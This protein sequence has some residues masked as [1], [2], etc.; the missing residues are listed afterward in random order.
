MSLAQSLPAQDAAR[1]APPPSAV[2]P[3]SPRRFINRELS[4]LD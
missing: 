3:D 1:D 4:W 2:A